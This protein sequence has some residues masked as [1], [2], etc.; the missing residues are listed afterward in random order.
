MEYF[1]AFLIQDYQQIAL[2]LVVLYSVIWITAKV[3][4]FYF[5]TS[6]LHTKMPNIERL[7][8]KLDIGLAALNDALLGKSVIDKSYYSRDRSPRTVNELGERLFKESG[9][10]AAFA[11]M[12]DPLVD[13]LASKQIHSLLQLQTASLNVMIAHRN[14]PILKP[15]QDFVYEHPTYHNTP[16]GYTDLLFVVSLKLRDYYISKHPELNSK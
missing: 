13:E 2:Y 6:E 15:L 4:G 10:E 5:K 14:D 16:L 8:E 12:K 9:A 7:L 11:A 3:S 1:F